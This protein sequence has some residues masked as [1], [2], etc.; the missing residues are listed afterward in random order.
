LEREA[1]LASVRDL[2]ARAAGGRGGALFIIGDAGLGKSAV[3]DSARRLAE[4][5]FS[6]GLGRGDAVEATLPF[7]VLDQALA[8]LQSE[9]DA[10][11]LTS[12]NLSAA[13]R[14]WTVLRQLRQAATRPLLIELDDLQWADPDSLGLI[15]LLCRRLAALPVALIGTARPWPDPAL[16]MAEDLRAA[17]LADLVRLAPLSVGA[18]ETLL[19]MRA[20]TAVEDVD[21]ERALAL[22]GG[23][24]QLLV[25]LAE[26]SA[27]TLAISEP[28]YF[29]LARF[30]DIDPV[31]CR[32]VRAA[33]VLG[34]RFRTAIA[35]DMAG[36]SESQ[37]ADVLDHLLKT[38][39]LRDA[40]HDGAEFTHALIRQA[41]Y[42]Q[43]TTPARVHLHHR[44]FRALLSGNASAAEAAKHAREAHLVGDVTAIATLARA[45][46]EAFGSGAIR[47]AR[48]HFE[49]AVD[50]AGESAPS[51]LL[52]ELAGAMLADGAS[53]EAMELDERVLRRPSL[54]DAIRAT[55]LSHLGRSAF[56]AGRLERAALAFE[57]IT[58][59]SSVD[60]EVSV[61]AMLDY[62]FWTW[63]CLGPRAGLKVAARA[64]QLASEAS[65]ALR[66]SADAAWGLCAW[67]IG[68]PLGVVVATAAVHISEVADLLPASSVHWALE[69]SGV[70]GDVAV[71]A[72][73]FDQAEALF[74]RLSRHAEQ[75]SE[76]FTLFHATFSWTDALCRL[77]RLEEA[78]VLVDKVFEMADV[79]PGVLPF[80]AAARALVL[81][82]LGRLG[83][84]AEWCER[85]AELANGHQWF[86]VRGYDLHRRATLAWRTGRAE[87][88][89]SLFAR[90]EQ[91]ADEWGLRDPSS[92]PW[93]ADAISAHVACDRDSDAQRV[94]QRLAAASDLPSL[95]P[96]VVAL[97]GGAALAEHDGDLERAERLYTEAASLQASMQLPLRRAE[98]LTEFGAF[99]VRHAEHARARPPLAE[100]LRLAEA[101]GGRWHVDRARAAWRRAGGRE[102][103]VAPGNLTPQETSVADLV[104][105]G[106]T[107]RQIARQLFLSEN[108]VETHLAHIYRKLGIRRRWELIARVRPVSSTLASRR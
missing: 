107:N 30:L 77:G 80:A 105:A 81:L 21:V 14:F 34:T 55:A 88:A 33:S 36:M 7:G 18:A 52:L 79:A 96:R 17:D 42:D 12:G 68:N 45:G 38:G 4:K 20:L 32:F 104:G 106:R 9:P 70:P 74:T 26:A 83:E 40:D 62:A 75:H 93:A 47:A 98:T 92:I 108:T 57:T 97:T 15:H 91:L 82:E 72:E 85:L 87:E 53:G 22:T 3:L 16:R 69:P 73:R 76:P 31:E 66:A 78:R 44:A 39:L 102:R 64:R 63:A 50:L 100:A 84:A 90:L 29:L 89:C 11:F 51:E 41:V 35:A 28:R 1:A 10:G 60:R 94:V 5:T 65:A 23:N 48:D 56:V 6:V 54:P 25:Q 46:R 24:P 37:A 19:R 13:R 61:R 99:L 59:L 58:R 101:A 8:P 43:I 27:E 2:F 95:W 103:R 86:L 71:W 67:G 49:T